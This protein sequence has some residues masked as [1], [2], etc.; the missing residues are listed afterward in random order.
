MRVSSLTHAKASVLKHVALVM[1]RR[2][3]LLNESRLS[4]VA[5]LALVVVLAHAVVASAACET[6]EVMAN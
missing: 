5:I 6:P 1:V 2:A 4:E 3:E